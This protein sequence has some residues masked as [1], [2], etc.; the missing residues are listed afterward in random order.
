MKQISKPGLY[1][2][3]L[4]AEAFALVA[5]DIKGPIRSK[6]M[7]QRPDGKWDI[8]IS[9]GLLDQLKTAALP[10]ENLSDTVL[11][12]MSTKNGAN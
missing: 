3:T 8:A 10:Q 7:M 4:S 1:R 11:R 5:A 12:I 6:A 2:L 9:Y